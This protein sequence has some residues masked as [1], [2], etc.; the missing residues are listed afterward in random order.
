MSTHKKKTRWNALNRSLF[1][2]GGKLIKHIKV[3]RKRRWIK[4]EFSTYR[5]ILKFT[6]TF[7]KYEKHEKYEKHK[8]LYKGLLMQ[9]GKFNLLLNENLLIFWLHSNASNYSG[10]YPSNTQKWGGIRKMLDEAIFEAI[11][12]IYEV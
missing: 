4:Y 9:I 12:E 1:V 6:E 5:D 8:K 2:W 3:W 7:W 11:W 10:K